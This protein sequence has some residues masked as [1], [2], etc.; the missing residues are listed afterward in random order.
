MAKFTLHQI[1]QKALQLLNEAP[2]GMRYGE[3]VKAVHRAA[4][5]TPINSVHGGVHSLIARPDSPIVRPSKGLWVLKGAAGAEGS[6]CEGDVAEA[7]PGRASAAKPAEDAFY[8][9][10]ASWLRDE[11]DEATEALALGGAALK[12]KWG[13]PDV[14]GVL[15]PRTGD[16]VPFPLEIIA[17]EVKTDPTQSITAFGQACAYRLFAH[18]VYLAMPESLPKADLDRLDSLC[19]LFGVGLILFR[20]DPEDPGYRLAARA[21]RHAPD[22][23][24]ANE[25]ARRLQRHAPNIFH[26]LF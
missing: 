3:L 19:V 8:G 12:D 23:F 10:L 26:R 21:Q 25:F 9:S 17:V 22:M 6:P 16:F 4:P 18:R 13:T 20:P 15:K 5:D 24:F 7:A 2:Q 11:A 14:I 1:R